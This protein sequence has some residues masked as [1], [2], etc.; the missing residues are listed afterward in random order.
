MAPKFYKWIFFAF[1][2]FYVFIHGCW[3][4]YEP[5]DAGIKVLDQENFDYSVFSQY[6]GNQLTYTEDLT[7]IIQFYNSWCG[8]C[9]K[10]SRTYK[11][12]G[13]KSQ[14][15]DQFLRIGAV[16]CAYEENRDLCI[17]FNILGTPAIRSFAPHS[18]VSSQG[19]V[20]QVKESL[21][22]LV[23]D[24]LDVLE[25]NKRPAEL[26]TV[27]E[28]SVTQLWSTVPMSVTAL[29]VIIEPIGSHIG[30]ESIMHLLPNLHS[31]AVRRASASNRMLT[32]RWNLNE[33]LPAIVFLDRHLPGQHGTLGLDAFRSKD[34]VEAFSEAILR[35][36]V[37][38]TNRQHIP[39]R[40]YRRPAYDHSPET[41]PS[42]QR[43]PIQRSYMQL[44]ESSNI[45]SFQ[46][47]PAPKTPQKADVQ[48]LD[49][50]IVYALVNEVG[51]QGDISGKA[52]TALQSFTRAAVRWLPVKGDTKLALQS[53]DDIL[54]RRSFI[55]GNEVLS[56]LRQSGLDMSSR[57]IKWKHC[58]SSIPNRRGYP[59]GLWQ[60]FH[61][62]TVRAFI[63]SM[64]SRVNTNALG[65]D[66]VLTA[67]FGYVEHFFS[68]QECSRHLMSAVR[69]YQRNTEFAS[70]SEAVLYLWRTHNNV[71]MRLAGDYS[72]DPAH[73]K[74]YF[75]TLNQCYDCRES[76]THSSLISW[77]ESGVLN[78]LR[79]F[80]GT[81]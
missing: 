18:H 49:S 39:R 60:I 24:V 7:W 34:P 64:Q 66:G 65:P 32:E 26:Q 22:D 31:L 51:R 69:N 38:L 10:F 61:T 11:A 63:D 70:P 77:N 74:Q 28:Q 47:P 16:D 76:N 4:L 5:Y 25:T 45:N 58:R 53:L 3:G 46:L 2:F 80:Y 48:D 1:C 44:A 9:I 52:Y 37:E 81:I 13:N 33:K 40:P 79:Q 56:V 30:K 27:P 78:F 68:C 29:A 55:S 14:H 67:I 20:F 73:P 71:N 75:P 6:A 41:L 8:H 59:C 42:P 17:R 12:L 15:W 43:Y 72:E 21:E 50:A 19:A 62:M 23:K 36:D 35:A 54:R 57:R